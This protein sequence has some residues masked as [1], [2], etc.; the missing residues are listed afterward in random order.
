[1]SS[2]LWNIEERNPRP[3]NAQSASTIYVHNTDRRL[4][5]L[6]PGFRIQDAD[7]FTY[8]QPSF[9][10]IDDGIRGG[11]TAGSSSEQQDIWIDKHIQ[12][13]GFAGHLDLPTLRNIRVTDDGI[14]TQQVV[15]DPGAW[16]GPDVN[17]RTPSI[18]PA[19]PPLIAGRGEA[20]RERGVGR[21]EDED[22]DSLDYK[23]PRDGEGSRRRRGGEIPGPGPGGGLDF[24]M[25]MTEEE[26]KNLL[27]TEKNAMLDEL[28]KFYNEDRDI[29]FRY[30]ET[31]REVL[32]KGMK[33][34][35]ETLAVQSKK[36]DLMDEK[37]RTTPDSVDEKGEPIY[38]TPTLS[39]DEFKR[40]YEDM[41]S[42]LTRLNT[43]M[44]TFVRDRVRDSDGII[45]AMRTGAQN[46]SDRLENVVRYHARYTRLLIDRNDLNNQRR[47]E[48]LSNAIH[49]HID[50]VHNAT[51]GSLNTMERNSE[52]RHN[53][54][55][56]II[57]EGQDEANASFLGFQEAYNGLVNLVN[58]F[59][60]EQEALPDRIIANLN[61]IGN[62]VENKQDQEGLAHAI[63]VVE[64]DEFKDG[65]ND[66]RYL[67]DLFSAGGAGAN[68]FLHIMDSIHTLTNVGV[69]TRALYTQL[70]NLLAQEINQRAVQGGN[71]F[72]QI[73]QLR[74][75]VQN[76]HNVHVVDNHQIN[77]R[78]EYLLERINDIQVIVQVLANIVDPDHQPEGAPPDYHFPEFAGVGAVEPPLNGV[79]L[80]NLNNPL[81]GNPVQY[82]N[83]PVVNEVLQPIAAV[84]DDV[85][86]LIR[87]DDFNHYLDERKDAENSAILRDR[88]TN[89]RTDITGLMNLGNRL[90]REVYIGGVVDEKIDVELQRYRDTAE[91]R[92]GDHIDLF[93]QFYN[94]ARSRFRESDY[95]NLQNEAA[96]YSMPGLNLLESYEQL[97]I[98]GIELLRLQTL[99]STNDGGVNVDIL[100]QTPLIDQERYAAFLLYFMDGFTLHVRNIFV[101]QNYRTVAADAQRPELESM[102][103]H[104]NR[105]QENV[106]SRLHNVSSDLN[107][108]LIPGISQIPIPGYVDIVQ[109]L[110]DG[111]SD[112]LLRLPELGL[113]GRP[114]V[115][116]SAFTGGDRVTII[117]A[118]QI[119]MPYDHM[120]FDDPVA[121]NFTLNALNVS[122]YRN[123]INIP[124]E[125][126]NYANASRVLNE[127]YMER[128]LKFKADNDEARRAADEDAEMKENQ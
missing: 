126:E 67:K 49:E 97:A 6:L 45:D 4:P 30:A 106:L 37:R 90:R 33:S 128:I 89:I 93:N 110:R 39:G 87:G 84:V 111:D 92:F 12:T 96:Y 23:S 42:Q 123:G 8:P 70:N 103:R 80:D 64:N 31:E 56:D 17:D 18:T 14:P 58:E 25:D 115:N 116:A 76:I 28:M 5:D 22:K 72:D 55:S 59:R 9:L 118:E 99:R 108:S 105:I 50:D 11:F 24:I 125:L 81:M 69:D 85:V 3:V 112:I 122:R 113:L 117:G 41:Q 73:Q 43:V 20:D 119:A 127:T 121:L 7:R 16:A 53:E 61:V 26:F 21:F 32:Y 38:T 109:Q 29:D 46:V 74:N 35:T 34:I 40:L 120:N 57:I 68:A 13:V 48:T 101:S 79:N 82:I 19:H 104:F 66:I 44:D 1:M 47:D 54:M 124:E 88:I 95:F 52:D 27:Q 60:L 63:Q 91:L 78:L 51:R 114:N 94:N 100:V 15:R 2:S 75:G 77:F 62:M 10:Y 71:I 102:V 86:Q 107:M 36:L 83:Q 65:L 98:T